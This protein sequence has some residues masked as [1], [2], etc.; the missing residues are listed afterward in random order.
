MVSLSGQVAVEFLLCLMA[1]AV[2]SLVKG[3]KVGSR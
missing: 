2:F 1:A 3:V